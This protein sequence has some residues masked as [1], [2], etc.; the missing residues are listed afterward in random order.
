MAASG[1]NA[2]KAKTGANL[3]SVGAP[4]RDGQ[5][6]VRVPLEGEVKSGENV[7]KR[8]RGLVLRTGRVDFADLGVIGDHFAV[9]SDASTEQKLR[10]K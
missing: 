6:A 7:E 8:D 3:R 9:V 5:V 2:R 10:L 4:V 1:E